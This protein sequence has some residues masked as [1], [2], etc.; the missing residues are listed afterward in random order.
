MQSIEGAQMS[1]SDTL[2][3]SSGTAVQWNVARNPLKR[4]FDVLVSLATLLLLAPTLLLVALCI[5]LEDR[6]PVIFKQQRTGLNGAPFTIYKFRS[7]TVAHEN[8]HVAQA[9][10]GDK[11]VTRVGAIIR[12]L[13]ID[14]LPHLMN[15]LKGDMSLV[16]PRPHALSHDEVW[17]R[18]TTNYDGRFRAKPGLT[19]YAQVLGYRGELHSVEDLVS[20]I[21]AD[22]RY[23]ET[24]TLMLDVSIVLRTALLIF[25]DPRAY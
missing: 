6:G 16:G 14:E 19:G 9:T 11:R 18:Q 5:W 24:W 4:C 15:V 7:M 13:S 17:R 1:E 20:R 22:N 12:A 25:R 21:E 23:I 2:G 3:H 10:R 8:G